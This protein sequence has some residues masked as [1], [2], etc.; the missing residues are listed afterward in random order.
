[1]PTIADL[2]L[3]RLQEAG[4]GF[5]FGIPGGGS[6][7]DLI[8]AAGRA[9]VPF[10]LAATETG[11][12][13][14][15]VAQ[16]EVSG[17]PGV[18]LTTL[19]PGV[20]SVVNGVACASL[21]RAP[22]LVLT[23]SHAASAAAIFEH[24]RLAHRALLAPVA[25]WSA[26]ISP[27][28]ADAV[29]REAIDRATTD[30][31][32]PVHI[33][34]P[35]DVAALEWRDHGPAP[36][37]GCAGRIFPPPASDLSDTA[38]AL[39]DPAVLEPLLSQARTPLLL[40]GL[41]ARRP[42]DAEALTA[43]CASHGV[44]AM[45]TYKA[46][47][48]VPDTDAHF[49]GVFTNGAIEQAIL[50]Q[51]DL[52]IGVGLD[53]VELLPRPW[54]HPQPIVNITPWAVGDRHVPFAA[55]LVADVPSGMQLIG[56]LLPPARWDLDAVH[57]MFV[58]ER[59]RL[60][61]ESAQLSAHRVVQIAADA[62]ATRARVTVDA[63]AHMFPATMLWP[64]SE[65]NGMLISNGL[66]TMGFAL[67]AAI[68]AALVEREGAPG[69]IHDHDGAVVALTGDGGL[70]MCVG[71]LLTAVRE[72]LRVITIVFSDASLSLIDIKQQQRKLASSG[73]SLGMV[74]WCGLAG[75][76]G[77]AAHL[78]RDETEL[79]RA[80]GRALDHRGPSLIEA[81]IDPATYSETL[82]VVRG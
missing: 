28:N 2:I 68:G 60:C 73:V 33:E 26:T 1:M 80:V 37:D 39:L 64:V 8:A 79:D 5:I 17:R 77:V 11:A 10:V 63:G 29:V 32:G 41:G 62:A 4:V 76:M 61:P 78:A 20:A 24:Q 51:A 45:V 6:N 74:D 58:A 27:D 7:L 16:A 13:L 71:E 44:P 23:D 72:R 3:C 75:S 57:R 54:T 48:V 38:P 82:R 66:S 50:A 59:Q 25:K 12:A 55:Q 81:K 53:P 22:L 42:L 56:E 21:E 18:C 30:P 36:E 15:A 49:A 34:C 52:L 14:A 46:K 19:G 67:P 43:L 70:L 47:G 69:A 35:G 40:V 9:S 31:R 65:P